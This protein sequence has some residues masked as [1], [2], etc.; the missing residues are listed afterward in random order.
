MKISKTDSIESLIQQITVKSAAAGGIYTWLDNTL[1]FHTVYLEVQPKQIALDVANEEL[2]RAQQAFSKILARVQIL[3]D[4]LTEENLKMQRALAEKDDAVRTKERLA[5]QIDLA[6]RLVDG[7]ASSRIIWTKRV[8]TFKNDLE[9]L[10]GDVLLAST[11]I[12]YTGYFSRSYRINFV[13]KWRSAIATTKGVIPMRVDLQP[14]SIMI[15]DADIAEWMNQGLPADQTSYENAAI[16]IYC[17][18]WPL[19]VDPQGQGL[20]WIKN[21][22]TDKL[23]TLRYN[24]KGYL[25]RVEAAVRRGDTLLLECIEENIDSILEPIINRNLIRKGKIVKFGDKEID[26]HPNFRLIM[27]TRLANPH[28]RPEIQAQ[29]TLI[30]FSTTRDGLEAQLLAE[31]VAVERPDLEKS[32]FEVTKQQNEYKINLKKLE[33]SLLARL[34]TAEGNFIQNVELVVTLE[35]TVNTS[36]E[37]EQ[38]KI[39]AE[40]FSQQIDRTRELYRPTAI[41]ACI[42]YFIINDLSKI[43]P[44]YQFSLKAF[45]SVFLKA[46]DYAEQSEDL[47]IRIDNLIDAITFASYSYI[48]RGLFEE[49]K[50]IFTIQLLLQILTE[51]GEID[52][53]ELDLLL[54]NPQE[55]HA[56]SPVEFLNEKAWGSIKALSLLQIFH[57]LDRDIETSSKRWKKYVESEAPEL[58]KP[59]GEW[60]SKSTMQHLCILRAVRPDRMLYALKLFI[61][62]KLGKKYIESRTPDFSRTYEESSKSIPM[63]FILSPGVDPLK[64]VETLGKKL[65]YTSQAGKFY[66]I[67][68]GQGQEIVAENALEISAKEGHWIVLQNI[69]LVRHWLPILERKLER[70]LETG[71]EN[72]R[73]FMSAEPS[74]DFS[75]HVIPQGILENSIK[76]T[77]ES[78]TGKN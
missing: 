58:E 37:I 40:K 42:I 59:P 30:N 77:N 4:C 55:A 56:G 54:R 61:A 13:N 11:F 70:I 23:V 17:L 67:S 52:M 47:R 43:H 32:K 6:E 5:R 73:L 16:L 19:M 63:F 18:R 48:V 74:A 33:D 45:R 64:E 76:I 35:R 1:K 38:K 8:E 57:G 39:E 3:E 44:M 20:R 25:D 34:A 71:Q 65:G 28:F 7:L 75:T 15:D 49:H 78:H 24:S 14:L 46:I 62:E 9:T 21:L 53:V 66:N 60:K 12:S 41:R 10:L 72:F 51:K 29:T 50:L 27:Q 36:L 26:Y 31:I 2:S 68:L 22:F 69:H